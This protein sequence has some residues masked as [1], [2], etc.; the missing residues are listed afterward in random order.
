MVIMHNEN[1][2]LQYMHPAASPDKR[3]DVSA[4]NIS[5]SDMSTTPLAA[6]SLPFGKNNRVVAEYGHK[7]VN[8][9]DTDGS[10]L[11]TDTNLLKTTGNESEPDTQKGKFLSRDGS[12][13]KLGN[14]PNA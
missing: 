13:V 1:G 10:Q 2:T 4:S 6:K 9:L 5:E 8:I 11:K 12:K 3:D 7:V 14:A